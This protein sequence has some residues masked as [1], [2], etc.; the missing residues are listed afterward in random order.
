MI[1]YFTTTD[2]DVTIGVCSVNRSSQSIVSKVADIMFLDFIEASVDFG[3]EVDFE[4]DTVIFKAN[5]FN[6][7]LLD[8]ISKKINIY[9]IK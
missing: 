7:D 6:E 5:E 8:L 4:D 9:I 3:I 1:E 2:G